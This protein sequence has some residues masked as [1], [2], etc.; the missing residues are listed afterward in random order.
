MF[1]L[2]WDGHDGDSQKGG[3]AGDHVEDGETCVGR[4]GRGEEEAEQIH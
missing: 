4:S 2:T 1:P 3:R